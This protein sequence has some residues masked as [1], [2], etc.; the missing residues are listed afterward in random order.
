MTLDH[1]GR[2]KLIVGRCAIRDSGTYKCVAT[3]EVGSAQTSVQVTVE[4]RQTDKST[5]STPA[6]NDRPV[7]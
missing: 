1:D 6:F 7:P 5:D 2:V 4:P 3:N